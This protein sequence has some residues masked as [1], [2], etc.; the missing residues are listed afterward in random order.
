[1]R[2]LLPLI[3][4]FLCSSA[5]ADWTRE[6]DRLLLTSTLLLCADWLQTREIAARPVIVTRTVTGDSATTTYTERHE[7]NPLLG[8]HPSMGRVNTYFAVALALNTAC[9]LVLPERERRAVA[10]CVVTVEILAVGNNL[11]AG[12]GFRF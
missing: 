6:D 1:M 5:S 4:L 3:L 12:I 11:C 10:A 9:L 2:L 8:A 7:L